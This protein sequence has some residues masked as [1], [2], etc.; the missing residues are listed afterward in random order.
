MEQSLWNDAGRRREAC[1]H[2]DN[3]KEA[4]EPLMG[5]QK[6]Q[7]LVYLEDVK[8]RFQSDSLAKKKQG[9][10]PG[11]TSIMTA[12]SGYPG[13]ICDGSEER[14]CT[15]WRVCFFPSQSLVNAEKKN[16]TMVLTRRRSSLNM[17]LILW[18]VLL[19]ADRNLWYLL[20]N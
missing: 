3:F 7:P 1:Q 5:A 6:E 14:E 4:K 8:N 11:R 18:R 19:R 9:F 13:K 17:L 16:M 10:C 15:G 20:Q 12:G 2:F